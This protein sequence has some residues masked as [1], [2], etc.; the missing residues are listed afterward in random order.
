M[1]WRIYFSQPQFSSL[2]MTQETRDQSPC[3]KRTEDAWDSK[4]NKP[5]AFTKRTHWGRQDTCQRDVERSSQ[6]R[7]HGRT[8]IIPEVSNIQQLILTG[9]C[10]GKCWKFKP[11]MRF[12]LF[13]PISTSDSLHWFLHLSFSSSRENLFN[14]KE[15][16]PWWSL[17]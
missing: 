16:C 17:P 11:A 3:F 15:N 12:T 8:K 9:V 2:P 5:S 13:A 14:V 1:Y 4:W 6:T 7:G 10:F